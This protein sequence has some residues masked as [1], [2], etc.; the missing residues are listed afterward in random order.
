MRV[1]YWNRYRPN[2]SVLINITIATRNRADSFSAMPSKNCSRVPSRSM[3]ARITVTAAHSLF[4]SQ[5]WGSRPACAYCRTSHGVGL[6]A[7][8]RYS[9]NQLL[10][11]SAVVL[12]PL[13]QDRLHQGLGAHHICGGR[14]D[15]HAALFLEAGA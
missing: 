13:V 1:E 3:I 9:A 5:R 7:G 14:I 4:A 15:Q 10:C 6:L 2:T 8:L 12:R 11:R